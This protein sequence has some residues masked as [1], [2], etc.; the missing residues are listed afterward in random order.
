MNWLDERVAL[1]YGGLGSEAAVSRD[2]RA[3]LVAAMRTRGSE[4]GGTVDSVSPNES[5]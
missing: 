3:E 4:L 5:F 2:G 1:L